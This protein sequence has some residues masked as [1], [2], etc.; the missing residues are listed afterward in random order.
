MLNNN[1]GDELFISNLQKTLVKI[2]TDHNLLN[3]QLYDIEKNEITNIIR[4][5]NRFE[6]FPEWAPDG[7]HLYFVCTD[8]DK[9]KLP[10]DSVKYD[11]L[12]IAFDA[13]S[14]SWGKIERSDGY[15][16]I[17]RSEAT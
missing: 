15:D 10:F 3:K 8:D 9:N 11:I 7:K 5:E 13:D 14:R 2:C 12:R 16:V 1:F 17:L 4:T 6:S